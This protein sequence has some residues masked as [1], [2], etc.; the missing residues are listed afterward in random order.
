MCVIFDALYLALHS[1]EGRC[2]QL[3][4]LE[5]LSVMWVNKGR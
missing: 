2:S 5:L 4:G 1:K 3:E